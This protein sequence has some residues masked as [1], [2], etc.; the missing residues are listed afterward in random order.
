MELLALLKQL[1]GGMAEAEMHAGLC[2]CVYE[3]DTVDGGD[4]VVDGFCKLQKIKRRQMC[5]RCI[6]VCGRPEEFPRI[7]GRPIVVYFPANLLA[8]YRKFT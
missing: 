8:Q 1:V 5:G 6:G 2:G 7:S 3:F 4:T